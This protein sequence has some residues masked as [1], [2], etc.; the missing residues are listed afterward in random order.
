MNEVVMHHLLSIREAMGQA[1]LQQKKPAYIKC[2]YHGMS[3]KN[4][5]SSRVEST[6]A[7]NNTEGRDGKLTQSLWW[8]RGDQVWIPDIDIILETPRFWDVRMVGY[9]LRDTFSWNKNSQRGRI[10]LQW[11][12][13]KGVGDLK[14][15]LTSDKV[16]Q[17]LE[18]AQLDLVFLSSSISS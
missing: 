1:Q 8:S 6:R 4:S 16:M 10:V 14:N 2:I 3:S 15:T 5:R 13:Q 7:Q 18:F 12:K 17:C 11:T 9:L